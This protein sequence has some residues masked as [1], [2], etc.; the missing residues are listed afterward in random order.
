[1]GCAGARGP[2][3]TDGRTEAV[4][5]M[6]G[7]I[8]VL[9]AVAWLAATSEACRHLAV[10]QATLVTAWTPGRFPKQYP[11]WRPPAQW[12]QL[13]GLSHNSSVRLWQLGHMATEG[14]RQFAESGRVG[15]LTGRM[16]QGNRGVLDFFHA[17]AVPKGSGTSEVTFFV[18]PHHRRVS[19]MSR[20]VPSPDWFVGVD[21]LDLCLK[22]RWRDRVTVD[23]DPLDAGTDQGLTFT[24]PRWASQPA[25][26]ISRIS[27]RR[28]THPAGS[29][30]YPELERLPR[31]GYFQFR[32]LREYALV[33]E[34]ARQDVGGA[35]SSNHVLDDQPHWRDPAAITTVD[36]TSGSI[37]DFI[38]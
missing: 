27:S 16:V 14:V 36:P 19:T 9:A 1:K 35:T 28:P 23:A 21:S 26:N 6:P 5:N 38:G 29:F 10:Y 8:T 7:R 34:R 24:A 32:K 22:G 25:A 30:Y 12:S 18:D 11:H 17:P 15:R 3:Y 13:V 20:L 2:L 31:I 33:L 37:P 4:R